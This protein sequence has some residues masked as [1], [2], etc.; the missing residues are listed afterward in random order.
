MIAITPW[1]RPL[2]T[3]VHPAEDLYTL[4]PDYLAR[5]RQ[6]GSHGAIVGHVETTDEAKL[7]LERFDGLILSGG[8]D[9]DPALYGEKNTESIEPD[10]RADRSDIAYLEAARALDL[11]VLAVCRGLQVMNV[12]FGG[13]L[14]QDI[15]STHSNHPPRS[16]SGDLH[17][18]ADAFLDNRHEVELTA[19]SLIAGLLQSTVISVNSLHHQAAAT[20]GDGLVVTGRAG[21]GTIEVIEHP[22]G[23]ILAVQWHPEWLTEMGQPLFDW[24]VAAAR[25]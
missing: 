16:D 11:P 1:R 24:L 12:A 9:V 15:W 17:A 7:V 25:R 5:L 20:I 13:T 3:W 19:G 2:A 10:I 6:A 21:D 23:R 14:H 4:A 18:D 8:N 22:D